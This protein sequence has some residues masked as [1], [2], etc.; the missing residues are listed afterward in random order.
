MCFL[1]FLISERKIGSLLFCME[2]FEQISNYLITKK[3]NLCLL[4]L[5]ISSTVRF[6]IGG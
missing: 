2:I 1:T 6:S 4:V 3:I 5:A